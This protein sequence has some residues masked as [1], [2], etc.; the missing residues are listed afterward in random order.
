MGRKFWI[1]LS[2]IIIIVIILLH[3]LIIFFL[4]P[5]SIGVCNLKQK[6][7]RSPFCLSIYGNCELNP[8]ADCYKNYVLLYK[9]HNLCE[10]FVNIDP[11]Y[12]SKDQCYNDYSFY[13]PDIESCDR[14]STPELRLNCFYWIGEVKNDSTVCEYIKND[15]G[16]NSK[17]S[18]YSSLSS[19]LN[20]V[21]ICE[22]I[23]ENKEK[24]HCYDI[25]AYS[26]KDPNICEKII[27][28]NL[29]VSCLDSIA[30]FANDASICERIKQKTGPRSIDSCYIHFID[31]DY[32]LNI[33]S[34]SICEKVSDIQDKE[35]SRDVCYYKIADKR[36]NLQLCENIK[37]KYFKYECIANVKRSPN[38]KE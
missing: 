18:C 26:T 16:E 25:V 29:S 15:S 38:F 37:D 19:S 36:L 11:T 2:I 27:N 35:Y 3:N 30:I 4:P 10:K 5:L 9:N 17:D 34:L 24:D 13:H 23:K 6:T 21:N 28:T 32:K 7:I 14:V 1:I 22:N 33:S 12:Y 20:D 8:R 31:F